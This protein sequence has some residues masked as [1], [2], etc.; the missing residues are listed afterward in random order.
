MTAVVPEPAL[1]AATAAVREHQGR[2]PYVDVARAALTAALPHLAPT[3]DQDIRTIIESGLEYGDGMVPQYRH[4]EAT[5]DAI[6]DALNGAPAVDR[7]T[8]ARLCATLNLQGEWDPTVPPG[9]AV[10]P[11]CREPWESEPSCEHARAVYDHDGRVRAHALREA[12]DE[13]FRQAVT[14]G[15][16]DPPAVAQ[17]LRDRA[18]RIEAG[19]VR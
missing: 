2:V 3:V 14:A 18:D 6:W 13:H 16:E 8:T 17:W 11:W 4:P 1:A 12:A 5:L 7:D 9:G 10:C 15:H 19:E